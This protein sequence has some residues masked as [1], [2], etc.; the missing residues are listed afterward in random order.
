MPG[1]RRDSECSR[2]GDYKRRG[3]HRTR[4][5]EEKNAISSRV[6]HR[7]Q[8]ISQRRVASGSSCHSIPEFRALILQQETTSRELQC[9]ACNL[10]STATF[11][12]DPTERFGKQIYF[13]RW[14]RQRSRVPSKQFVGN[15]CL[16][17]MIEDRNAAPEIGD[18]FRRQT[19]TDE[20]FKAGAEWE[21][22]MKQI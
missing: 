3:V 9:V 19:E 13:E 21:R 7:W 5:G 15:R 1:A 12:T 8:R 10:T 18:H 2:S 11:I 16:R 14:M 6:R 17:A 4:P 20:W 22:Q